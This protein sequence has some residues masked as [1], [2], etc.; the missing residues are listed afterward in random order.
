MKKMFAIVLALMLCVSV[1][2]VVSFAAEGD[3]TI[4]AKV[5]AD[6]ENVGAYTWEPEDLGAWPG[7][8]MTKNGDWYEVTMPG[9]HTTVI[10]NSASAQTTDLTIETGKDVWIVVGEAG[11]DGKFAAEV[12]YT[13]PGEGGNE[14]PG[15]TEKPEEKPEQ[16]PE[17]KPVD[18]NASYYVAGVSALCGSEW[19]QNDEANK[20]TYADG[21][22]SITY[23]NVAAG[24]Y[25]LKVTDGTWENSWGGN[26]ENG[27][28]DF[29]V[30][31]ASD[32]TVEFNASKQ[33][34]SIV[35][36]DE[37]IDGPAKAG[38][39]SLVGVSLALLAATAGLV[40]VVS[41]KKE[42]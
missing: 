14:N 42:F 37:R 4:H 33:Q 10:I 2:S 8:T 40:V 7:A 24:N 30:K 15:T 29:E 25:S 35:I 1:L 19:K 6:W 38:D 9:T 32:V 27:N 22:F 39:V 21:V 17:E 36:G 31:E 28:F 34:V 5:P 3:V 20:M 41:K 16:K 12:S 23:K 11:A 13:A 26:G 18:P